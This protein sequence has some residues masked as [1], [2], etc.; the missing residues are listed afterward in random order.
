MH[1][2]T[3]T[4]LIS[5]KAVYADANG[6]HSNSP[7]S[8]DFDGPVSETQATM[9]PREDIPYE[10]PEGY[11]GNKRAAELVL[12]ESGAPVTVLR[13]SKIHGEGA[14]PPR[15]WVY[16]KRVL[17]GRKRV[18]FAHRGEGG[19]HTTAAA[20]IAALIETV[21]A[22]PGARILN[23]ADPDAPNALAI[24]R[25]VAQHLGHSWEE[26]LV[27]GPSPGRHPWKKLPPFVLDMSAAREL[28]YEPVGDFAA[29][30]PAEIDWLVD[31]RP[32]VDDE[33]FAGY[34]D[35][36]AEDAAVVETN[37]SSGTSGSSPTSR[38]SSRNV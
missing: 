13:P 11:G 7:T 8:P 6:N 15:T 1:D 38:A 12:L 25:T 26:V 17:D 22:K 31:E 24:A 19:D 16:V 14:S 35:Y 5:S 28:G 34:F 32:P 18:F 29:T 20:N 23:S 21:A 27:D 37:R 9:P 4:V 36:A 10:S 2:V 30:V 3:S 33:F